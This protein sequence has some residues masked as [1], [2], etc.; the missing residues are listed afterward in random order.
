MNSLEIFKKKAL[1]IITN[2]KSEEEIIKI[3]FNIERD[4]KFISSI[5]NEKSSTTIDKIKN[6]AQDFLENLVKIFSLNTIKKLES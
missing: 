1:K 4:V 5:D 6:L 2:K 3:L